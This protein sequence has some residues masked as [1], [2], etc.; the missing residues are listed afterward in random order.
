METKEQVK[1]TPYRIL[2]SKEVWA[3]RQMVAKAFTV[4]GAESIVHEHNCYG[5]LL[6]ALRE[7]RNEMS[8]SGNT[9]E[10]SGKIALWKAN[11]AIAKAEGR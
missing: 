8:E 6:E 9:W 10:K 11:E 3:E 2:N 7:I 1:H 5:E 4:D